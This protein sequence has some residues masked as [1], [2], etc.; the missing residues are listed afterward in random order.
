[1]SVVTSTTL[2]NS[3]IPTGRRPPTV[4]IRQVSNGL[5]SRQVVALVEETEP[6]IKLLD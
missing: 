5:S 4:T 1:M 6:A 2:T 3:R